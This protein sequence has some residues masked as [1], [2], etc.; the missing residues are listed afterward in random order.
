MVLIKYLYYCVRFCPPG[1]RLPH[2]RS[3]L[4][5]PEEHIPR[6]LLVSAPVGGKYAPGGQKRRWNDVVVEDLNQAGLSR[7]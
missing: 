6:Q 2:T 4:G 1:A 7:V 3:C 5:M